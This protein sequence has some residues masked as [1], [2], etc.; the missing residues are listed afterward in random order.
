MPRRL[1]HLLWQ[2][3][4]KYREMAQKCK[5]PEKNPKDLPFFTFFPVFRIFQPFLELVGGLTTED[6][7]ISL[8]QRF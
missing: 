2:N 3:H 1:F 7:I 6:E 5:K 8:T 4:L